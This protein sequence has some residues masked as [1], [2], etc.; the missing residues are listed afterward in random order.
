[1]CD[2]HTEEDNAAFLTTTSDVS[3]RSFAVLAASA[4]A[5]CAS[6]QTAQ[7]ETLEVTGADVTVTTPDGAADAFFVHPVRGRHAA[8]VMWPD[9]MGIRPAFRQM[10]TRLAQSGYAVLVVN[11]YYRAVKGE[12]IKTGESFADP[13][14]RARIMPYAQAQ[15][16]TTVDTDAR[17]FTMFLD[18]QPAVDPRRKIGVA[19]YCMS[20]PFTMRA[21]ALL[22]DR[23]GAGASFHGGG[24][25]TA[26]PTSPH[27]LI[28]KMKAGFLIAIAQNDDERDPAAKDTLRAAFATSNVAAEIE[29]YP[30]QHGWCPPDS[31]VYDQIQ[32]DRAWSRMLA[33]FGTALA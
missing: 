4:M 32:A 17:A 27:L 11:P 20:G 31:R 6:G 16:P 14:V 8:V 26:T 2:E 12:V 9:V 15:S 7:G 13:D 18:A 3:R 30:A 24:L 23:V 19:G 28:P 29:V 25:A 21:A 22:P 10:G 1:M 33:L 5:A